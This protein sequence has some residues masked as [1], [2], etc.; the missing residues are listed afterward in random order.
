MSF[1]EYDIV[2]D[3]FANAGKVSSDVKKILTGLHTPADVIRRVSV[4]CY[5]AEINMIIHSLGGKIYLDIDDNS[6][7]LIFADKGPGI[8][9][10]EKAKQKGWSTASDKAREWGFGAGMGLFNIERVADSFNLES[11]ANSPTTLTIKFNV[12]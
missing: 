11:K 3:D 10:I 7:Q 2:K 12:S 1:K 8:P 4:A 9:D 6:I 5:E